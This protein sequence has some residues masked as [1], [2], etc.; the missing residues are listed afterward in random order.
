MLNTDVF[1][2]ITGITYKPL[3]CRELTE[4]RIKDL[5]IAFD[6]EGSFII[7]FEKGVKIAAS[8]WVSSKRTRSYPYARVYDTLGFHVKKVTIIG[9]YHFN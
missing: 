6:N 3:V 5:N 9:T 7:D 1:A 8:W 4:Y 2:K